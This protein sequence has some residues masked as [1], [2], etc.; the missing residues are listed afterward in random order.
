MIPAILNLMNSLGF[1]GNAQQPMAQPMAQP[2]GQQGQQ[3]PQQPMGQPVNPSVDQG[4]VGRPIPNPFIEQRDM[5]RPMQHFIGS[6]LANYKQGAYE[7]PSESWANASDAAYKSTNDYRKNINDMHEAEYKRRV[8]ERDSA[9]KRERDDKKDKIDQR[10]YDELTA[11]QKAMVGLKKDEMSLEK[12]KN[13]G[14]YLSS[15]QIPEGA[16]SYKS[17]GDKVVVRARVKEMDERAARLNPGI[18][19]LKNMEKID[20]IVKQHPNLYNSFSR[21][22][23]ATLDEDPTVLKSIYAGLNEDEI[24]AA[25]KISKY[26]N[27]I[28]INMIKTFPGRT[29]DVLKLALKATLGGVG[30]TPEAFAAIKQAMDEENLRIVN[31]AR[32]AW[33]GKKGHYYMPEKIDDQSDYIDKYND[34][35]NKNQNSDEEPS[36]EN[37]VNQDRSYIEMK[38]KE[39]GPSGAKITD[40][41][42][43]KYRRMQ[44]EQ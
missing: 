44:G 20:E 15:D 9:Y 8:G 27:D 32:A 17:M 29:T 13:D 5:G 39:L 37:N 14:N 33:G 41:Q 11:Y 28:L 1:G 40:E 36:L 21:I 43:L 42:I 12:D 4:N 3:M 26:T 25:Q 38:R 7:K 22:A 6:M 18:K 10:E 30:T 31:D 34:K 19:N 16:I 24:T 35:Y 23:S 2:M